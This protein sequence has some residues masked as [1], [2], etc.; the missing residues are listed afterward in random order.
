[1][2]LS[3]RRHGWGYQNI[4]PAAQAAP[5]QSIKAMSG[6]QARAPGKHINPVSLFKF[7]QSFD[8]FRFRELGDNSAQGTAEGPGQSAAAHAVRARLTPGTRLFSW[9]VPT[10]WSA[11]FG[12]VRKSDAP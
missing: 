7:F 10:K 1:M 4:A 12:S 11:G 9:W 3:R 8:I 5:G 2:G 6:V